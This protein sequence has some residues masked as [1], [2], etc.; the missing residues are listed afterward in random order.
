MDANSLIIILVI[1]GFS[2]WLAGQIK[3]GY[4]FGL[5]GNILVGIVG[6]FVGSWMFSKMGI[7]AGGGLLGSIIMSVVGALVLLVLIGLVRSK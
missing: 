5:V 1:G 4:G 2:G 6:S 7:S 3:N